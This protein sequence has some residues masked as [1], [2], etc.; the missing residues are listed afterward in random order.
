MLYI[1]APTTFTRDLPGKLFAGGG[2]TGCGD[3]QKPFYTRL[4][5]GFRDGVFF[6][7]RRAKYEDT[8][9]VGQQQIRWEFEH[10]NRAD[11]IS[12]WFTPE[13]LCPITLFELGK[14]IVSTKPVFVGAHPEYKRSFDLHV[15]CAL[16][17][18]EIKI[19]TSLEE[20]ASQVASWLHSAL[21]AA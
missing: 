19:A 13:T 17:R 1:E 16:Q 10:M 12:F 2:I 4:D 6:N 21:K 11:A 18:P 5:R 20:L 9:E 15:Q 7:P 3:W 8:P 14:W